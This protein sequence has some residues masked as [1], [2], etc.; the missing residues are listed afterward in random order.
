MSRIALNQGAYA[1][2]D[3]S[4]TILDAQLQSFP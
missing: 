4:L 2:F 1:S 3:L